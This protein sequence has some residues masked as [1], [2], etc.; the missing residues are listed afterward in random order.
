MDLCCYGKNR[1][2]KTEGNHIGIS[3]VQRRIHLL[4]GKEYGLSYSENT[5]GGVTAHIRL[6]LTM[7]EFL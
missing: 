7:E 1:A 2:K 3:N 5:D 4:C 6:P